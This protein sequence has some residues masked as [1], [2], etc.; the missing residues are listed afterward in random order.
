MDY[1]AAWKTAQ[2]TIKLASHAIENLEQQNSALVGALTT[3]QDICQS[4]N[5]R[6]PHTLLQMCDFLDNIN[7]IIRRA[8]TLAEGD[9]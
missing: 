9:K 5:Y 8:I 7:N 2:V 4:S 6:T 1:E 3:I